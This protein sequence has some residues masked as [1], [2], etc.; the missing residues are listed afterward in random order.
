[1]HVP[2]GLAEVRGKLDR[3][4]RVDAE[5]ARLPRVPRQMA[6]TLGPGPSLQNQPSPEPRDPVR[7]ISPSGVTHSMPSTFSALPPMKY[8][9]G[10]APW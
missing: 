9:S 2:L 6:R 7:T 5:A 1:V 3:A 10:P 4:L 8:V